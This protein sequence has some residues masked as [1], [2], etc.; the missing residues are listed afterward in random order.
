MGADRWDRHVIDESCASRLGIRLRDAV[1]TGDLEHEIPAFVRS[2]SGID[3]IGE[4]RIDLQP[5]VRITVALMPNAVR[6]MMRLA[7]GCVD[8]LARYRGTVLQNDQPRRMVHVLPQS[9][10]TPRH[11]RRPVDAGAGLNR[12]RGRG[13]RGGHAHVAT[14]HIALF[15]RARLHVVVSALWQWLEQRQRRLGRRQESD[16]RVFAGGVRTQ[17]H[18][19]DDGHGLPG[20]SSPR[21]GENGDAKREGVTAGVPFRYR[22]V[23]RHRVSYYLETIP[24][25][26]RWA[27]RA[28]PCHNG[29]TAR[30]SSPP[31]ARPP[32]SSPSPRSYNG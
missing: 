12:P 1:V 2:V 24:R 19:V 26:R 13:R 8:E 11:A 32:L 31:G 27:E 4:L 5:A 28:R 22:P 21:Q 9:V 18:A 23:P 29:S 20:G 25:R 15:P 16:R 3:E 17:I 6:L 30:P 14:P 10:A 7:L